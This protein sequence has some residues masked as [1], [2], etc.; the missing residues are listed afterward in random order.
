VDEVYSE[1]TTNFENMNLSRK[2]I[3]KDQG[4]GKNIFSLITYNILADCH[5]KGWEKS[6]Y[7][8]VKEESLLKKEGIDSKRHLLTMKEL[9]HFMCD[10]ILLQEVED[11]YSSVLETELQKSGYEYI[12]F[13]KVGVPEGSSLCYKKDKFQCIKTVKFVIHDAVEEICKTEG[14]SDDLI[15]QMK[16]PNISLIAVLK[17]IK[18]GKYVICANTHIIYNSFADPAIQALQA[19]LVCQKLHRVRAEVSSSFG[20]DLA[21]ISIIFGGDFNGEPDHMSIKLMKNGKLSDS[22]MKILEN[23]TYTV[24][25]GKALPISSPS[26]C[27]VSQYLSKYLENPLNLTSA[28]CDVM[29]HEP[30]VTSA[31]GTYVGC[32]DYIFYTSDLEVASVIDIARKWVKFTPVG[33]QQNNLHLIIYHWLQNLCFNQ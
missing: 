5:V 23:L 31:E 3:A 11:W 14:V 2:I 8:Y 1:V 21:D 25:G 12:F 7:P 15:N 29:G 24:E 17:D 30:V 4:E 13:Q 10:V 16:R 9:N 32:L 20:V 33:G 26:I 6:A 28:F 22:E 18:T 27:L 19:C